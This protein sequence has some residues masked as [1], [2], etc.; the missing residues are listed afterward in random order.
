M[1]VAQ[2]VFLPA[3]ATLDRCLA[4]TWREWGRLRRVDLEKSTVEPSR[5]Y[6]LRDWSYARRIRRRPVEQVKHHGKDRLFRR[7]SR[8]N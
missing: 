7:L 5:S 4:S 2:K 8:E 1:K 3:G 6:P